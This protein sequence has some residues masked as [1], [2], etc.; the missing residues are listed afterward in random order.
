MRH[1]GDPKVE[2]IA[3]EDL[4]YKSW[5]TE[6]ERQSNAAVYLMMDRSGSMGPEKSIIAK[7]FY[8][9]MVQFLKRKYKN[10]DLIFIAHDI[11]AFIVNQENFFKLTGGGGTQCSSAF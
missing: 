3:N 1:G 5:E 11:S 7:T 8:F 4:R 6:T 2:G 9:W 10:I